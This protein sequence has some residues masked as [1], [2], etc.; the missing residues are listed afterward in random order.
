M[1]IGFFGGSFNPPT[2][3]HISLAKK[4]LREC[5]LDKVVFVP[6]GDSYKKKELAPA[7]HRYNMLKLICNRQ[8]HLE[9]SDIEMNIDKE[10]FAID[11]FSL[12]E[13]KYKQDNIYFIMGADNFVNI[14]SWKDFEKLINKYKYIVFDRNNIDINKYISENDILRAC[15]KQITIIKIIVQQNLEV[16]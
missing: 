13:N 8:E 15:I 3:A 5:K 16:Y 7:K 12:I 9:V 4:A 11:A 6:M 14:T 10:M 2:N 1:R